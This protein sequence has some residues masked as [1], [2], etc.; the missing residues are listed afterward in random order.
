[1]ILIKEEFIGGE[2]WRRA[3]ELG[4][5][6][7]IVLWL[8]IKCYCAQHPDTEGFVPT[9]DLDRLPGAPRRAR[10]A[11]QALIDCGRMLPGGARGPGLV[12]PAEGGWR[13]H[14]Y[15]DHSA[16]P[17]EVA[18]RRERARLRKQAYRE[19]KR[20]ELDAVRRL[21]SEE[22]QLGA[23]PLASHPLGDGGA[24]HVPWDTAGHSGDIRGDTEGDVPLDRLAGARPPEPAQAPAPTRASAQPS[25]PQ[26]SPAKKSLRSL[27]NG[28]RDLEVCAEH[29]RF[30]AEHRIELEPILA[31]LR[32]DPRAAVLSADE[33]RARLGGL[34]MSAAG[35]QMGG[36]A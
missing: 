34:L 18:L 28:I 2:K 32:E 14:D 9:E 22:R 27:T 13:L 31:E 1:M 35:G 6:D 5:A 7:A 4:A 11:L 21:A 3:V 8:A 25:P 26:P 24:G 16:S 33:M 17:E 15:L 10:K 19:H 20:R 23:P 36:A 30:A 29:R 12:E